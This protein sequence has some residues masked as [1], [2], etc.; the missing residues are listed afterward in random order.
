[1]LNTNHP[2]DELLSA[3]ASHDADAT[4]D[5][6]LTDHVTSCTRCTALVDE[7]GAL[8]AILAELPD[9]KP[10]R[11]LRLLP[12]VPDPRADRIGGWARRVFGPVL[13]AGAALALVGTVGTAAPALSGMASGP[14]PASEQ[15]DQAAESVSAAEPGQEGAPGASQAELGPVSRSSASSAVPDGI[16]SFSGEDSDGENGEPRAA[17]ESPAAERS[18]W[19]MVLFTGVALMVAAGLLRWILVPRAG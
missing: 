15:V 1:M 19:P 14:G 7:F 5:A 6:P 3:L 10:N 17:V 16:G 9:L 4:T 2:D 8:R 11:P 18:P 12:E 13:A